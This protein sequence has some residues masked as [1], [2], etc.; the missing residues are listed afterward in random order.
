MIKEDLTE[1]KA[2]QMCPKLGT[3]KSETGRSL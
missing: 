1:M 2:F 3:Q